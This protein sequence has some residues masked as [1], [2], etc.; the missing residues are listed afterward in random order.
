MYSSLLT[1]GLP[2]AAA[3]L[4]ATSL[5]ARKKLA[6]FVRNRI[7]AYNFITDR[8]LDCFEVV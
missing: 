5:V 4:R 8:V 1:R 2:I 3:L 6:S 7:E